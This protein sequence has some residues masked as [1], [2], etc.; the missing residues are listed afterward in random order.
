MLK[1]LFLFEFPESYLDRHL[2]KPSGIRTYIRGTDLLFFQEGSGNLEIQSS[3]VQ[4][5]S[6]LS[7][8]FFQKRRNSNSL[9]TNKKFI[10]KDL[11]SEISESVT[12]KEERHLS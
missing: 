2:L 4:R 10:D 9:K 3:K 12:A 1:I 8:Y 7:G 6:Y 11:L 5:K